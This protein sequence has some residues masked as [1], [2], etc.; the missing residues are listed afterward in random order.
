LALADIDLEQ[1]LSALTID[2]QGKS[3]KDQQLQVENLLKSHINDANSL[4]LNTFYYPLAINAIQTLAVEKGETDRSITKSEFLN[5]IS[6]KDVVFSSWLEQKFGHEYYAKSV[7][8]KY[9]Q[10]ATTKLACSARIFVFN[11]GK[12]PNLRE[13][14]DLLTILG[15]RYSH[16]EHKR[17]PAHERF[18][19]YVLIPE[20]TPDEVVAIKK[21]LVD[22]G[23]PI[24]DGYPF[25][26]SPFSPKQL[27]AP[28]S[29]ETLYKIKFIPSAEHLLELTAEIKGMPVELFEFYRLAPN[30]TIPSMDAVR[31]RQIR[32]D[33]VEIIRE[34]I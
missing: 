18:C 6:K 20:A 15:K 1:F 32:A 4:D 8:R 3:Y 34:M 12:D 5:K 22:S 29:S 24:H 25:L 2:I 27:A 21:L 10:S 13:L 28:P 11:V 26:G 17:T 7:K 23:T 19:P 14:T 31:H 9:F 33:S 30:P 16:I